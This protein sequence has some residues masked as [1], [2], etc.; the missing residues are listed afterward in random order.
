MRRSS[1]LGKNSFGP[2]WK[3]FYLYSGHADQTLLV[4]A[5]FLFIIA[6]FLFL[7]AVYTMYWGTFSGGRTFY[8]DNTD[9]SKLKFLSSNKTE[10]PSSHFSLHSIQFPDYGYNN[11]L[12]CLESTKV[13]HTSD[14]RLFSFSVCSSY[15]TACNILSYCGT[16]FTFL[17]P[18]FLFWRSRKATVMTIIGFVA[19]VL[20]LLVLVLYE[21]YFLNEPF[22][23][24]GVGY[25]HI[26]EQ[27]EHGSSFWIYVSG[28]F[29]LLLAELVVLA[30]IILKSCQS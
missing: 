9:V 24:Y 1:T 30:S 23:Y 3:P 5:S 6:G 7:S 21:F 18:L 20:N 28:F 13:E 14:D 8:I 19:L 10:L 2:V 26:R 27:Y 4:V 12:L 15:L 16:T 25:N 22:T 17:T 11:V 29:V